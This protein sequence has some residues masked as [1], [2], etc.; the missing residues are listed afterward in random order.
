MGGFSEVT[1]GR[2][3]SFQGVMDGGPPGPERSR[4]EQGGGRH[5]TS[6]TPRND[7]AGSLG[8]EEKPPIPD[9]L[10]PNMISFFD[11]MR[12]LVGENGKVILRWF[13]KA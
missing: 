12:S 5:P 4:G 6:V 3:P 8:T 9:S 1:G 7:Q 10:L 2:S 13:G 11:H